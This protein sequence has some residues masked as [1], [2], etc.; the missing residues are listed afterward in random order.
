MEQQLVVEVLKQYM[1]RQPTSLKL[2]I[3]LYMAL[4]TAILERVLSEETRL[5]PT[6]VLAS[7][8]TIGRN[9]VVRVYEQFL[10]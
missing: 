10:L 8:L 7:E 2:R 5:P 1:D 9:T 4:R 3:R 6:R